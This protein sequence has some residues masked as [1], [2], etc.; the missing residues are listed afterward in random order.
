MKLG[1]LL[2]E[3]QNNYLINPSFF[4]FW[5][6]MRENKWH[7][8]GEISDDCSDIKIFFDNRGNIKFNMYS[9]TGLKPM[10]HQWL[11]IYTL[12]YSHRKRSNPILC[13]DC[14]KDIF[15]PYKEKGDYYMVNDSLWKKAT[16]NS[17]EER[18]LL[19]KKCLEKRIGRELKLDDYKQYIDAPV[20]DFLFD[21]D[22]QINESIDYDDLSVKLFNKVWKN[23][24]IFDMLDTYI[25][26]YIER[27]YNLE[28][29]QELI[30]LSGK[31]EIGDLVDY[32]I[33]DCNN[34]ICYQVIKNTFFYVV[35]IEKEKLI[36]ELEKD[37]KI[38]RSIVS[39]DDIDTI[40][41][42]S[43]ENGIGECWAK[44]EENA[45]P[46]NAMG[47]K[48]YEYIFEAEF[49]EED[50]LWDKTLYLRM[51]NPQEDEIRL[52]FNANIHLIS[53]TQYPRPYDRYH[54]NEVKKELNIVVPVGSRLY[55]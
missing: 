33:M 19:C 35:N 45:V 2:Q 27:N 52:N 41:K 42:Y 48:K 36:K 16:K 40:I 37:N 20:N 28:L 25:E 11:V 54:P 1:A 31:D 46:I 24:D 5:T 6:K 10:T 15:K 55:N 32:V 43:Q 38:Y 8:S 53:I 39:D 44:E 13:M 23:G 7:L 18:C 47:N 22:K 12:Y 26:C 50:V 4:V 21:E 29:I 9:F 17:N 49:N 14:G 3:M 51:M 30:K 34:K